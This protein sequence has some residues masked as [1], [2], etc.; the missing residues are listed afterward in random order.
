MAKEMISKEELK[1]MDITLLS[2]EELSKINGGDYID[3]DA[4]L[5]SLLHAGYGAEYKNIH[6]DVN[7]FLAHF[8]VDGEYIGAVDN[9]GGA[10]MVRDWKGLE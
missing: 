5:Q 1:E 7:G 6:T 9:S 8:M 10:H 2:K 4:L 3:C